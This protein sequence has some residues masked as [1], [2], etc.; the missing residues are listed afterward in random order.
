M[1]FFP[2]WGHLEE[3]SKDLVAGLQAA[4]AMIDVIIASGQECRL[5]L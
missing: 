3:L 5:M 4:V 2:L 1:D